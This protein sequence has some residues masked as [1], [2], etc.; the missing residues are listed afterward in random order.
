MHA[1]SLGLAN[2]AIIPDAVEEGARNV[3]VFA[4]CAVVDEIIG[5][6]E[7]LN[8]AYVTIFGAMF[9]LAESFFFI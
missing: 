4:I 7:D 1:F 2:L 8:T 6:Q 3:V 9:D 5:C